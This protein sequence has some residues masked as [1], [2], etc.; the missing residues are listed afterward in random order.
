MAGPGKGLNATLAA[1]SF[2]VRSALLADTP[3][4]LSLIRGSLRRVAHPHNPE[5]RS[6]VQS[7]VPQ[8]LNFRIR[9]IHRRAWDILRIPGTFDM[10]RPRV[11]ISST[12]YNLQQVRNDLENFIRDLG[13]EAVLNER[14]SV[15]YAHKERL[16]ES[17]YREINTC[18]IV[19]A[20]IGGRYGASS[21]HEPYSV[22]QMEL[23]TA[24]DLGKPLFIFVEQ[25]V[26]HEF[27]TYQ[28][29]K[30]NSSINY[31]A[32]DDVK[33]YAFLD[34]I[35]SLPKNNATAPF[36]SA[37]DIMAYL[38]EQWAGLFQ[39][40]LREH[41]LIGSINIMK[42]MQS[43]VETLNQLVNYVS[44]QKEGSDDIIKWLLTEDHPI[45]AQI[46]K[47]TGTPYRVYFKSKEEMTTWLKARGWTEG[48][49][50][51]FDL[52]EEVWVR[53][54]NDYERVMTLGVG[55]IFDDEGRLRVM[56]PDQWNVEWIKVDRQKKEKRRS[57][58]YDDLDDEIPF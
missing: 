39:R 32:V 6:A 50:V 30:T 36:G 37:Q 4:P 10:A 24:T 48:S 38:R 1:T 16:E 40:F 42:D 2:N 45:F 47:S 13:Y 28:Q 7:T 9:V 15:P 26:L 56:T 57:S 52:S 23:R 46:A 35:E 43:T 53:D 55:E 25:A 51:D 8:G 20:I 5:K 3:P 12:F 22:S 44:K 29:N 19:V 58:G 54:E 49:G 14:G 33:I 21:H 18:D 34:E 27:R 41:E 17:C 31:A 11:F